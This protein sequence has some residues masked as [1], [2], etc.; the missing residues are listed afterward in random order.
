MPGSESRSDFLIRLAQKLSQPPGIHAKSEFFNSAVLVL[1]VPLGGEY[2]LL[3]EKRA[4]SI[5]QGGE[6][7]FPGGEHD[8]ARDADYRATALREAAEETGIPAE[9]IEIL[10][11]LDTIV[12]PMGTTVDAFVGAAAVGDPAELPVNRREVDYLFTVPFSWFLR[13]PPERYRV[14]VEL[15]PSITDERTGRETVLLPSRE[16]GLPERYHRPWN[17]RPYPVLVYRPGKEVIWGLTA[18]LV[19]DLV[20]RMGDG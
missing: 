12:A 15:Q 20:R 7:C 9:A 6:V 18:R 16:L 11:V 14:A 8:P 1:L 2:H 4:L 19:W 3:F 17:G 5:R 13:N 10:G